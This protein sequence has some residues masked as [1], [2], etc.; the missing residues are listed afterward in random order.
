MATSQDFANWICTPALLPEYLMYALMAEGEGLRDFGE[1][2]THTTIYFPELK[3]LHL[4]LA[5]PHEQTE[6]VR[7][8]RELL[9][10]ADQLEARYTTARTHLDR[11]TPALLAK[12][13]RGELV[14]QDA[15]HASENPARSDT[16]RVEPLSRKAKPER[17]RR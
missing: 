17:N 1:G 11:L 12:A 10:L 5:S 7:R 8:A 15:G 3:A 6:I 13:F 16:G 14:P 9:R 4:A 2:T